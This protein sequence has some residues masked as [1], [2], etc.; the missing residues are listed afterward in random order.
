MEADSRTRA[1]L[2]HLGPLGHR[3]W[4]HAQRPGAGKGGSLQGLL[5]MRP[6]EFVQA[7]V[8]QRL[9]VAK[10]KAVG[11]GAGHADGDRIEDQHRQARIHLDQA[12]VGVE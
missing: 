9:C 3:A 8:T 6:G 7:G 1:E 12:D 2:L 4:V 5:G 11:D 10:A